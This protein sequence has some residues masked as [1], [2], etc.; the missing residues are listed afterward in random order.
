MNR[1]IVITTIHEKTE[2]ISRFQEFKDW[3]I[4]IIGDKKSRE[5]PSEGNIDFFSIERQ[6]GLGF[7]VESAL[8]VNHYSRKN[9]GYL[10]SL[11]RNSEIVYDTDDDNLP[12]DY[13]KCPE[14]FSNTILSTHE[15]FL[16]VYQYFSQESIWPRGFPLDLVKNKYSFNPTEKTSDVAV[17]QGLADKD[18]DVDAIFR[19]LHEDEIIFEEK[20][21]LVLDRGTY[22]PFNS[23]NTFW[24]SDFLELAYLPSTVTFRFTD[25]L[26]GY[27][28]QRIMWEKNHFLGFTKATVFQ[29]RNE[30]DLMKDF[31]SEIPCYLD[32]HKL[33]DT[34]DSTELSGDVGKDLFLVYESLCRI[35]IVESEELCILEAWLNDV[36]R[37][38]SEKS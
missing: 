12:Y 14:F 32:V 38:R 23:Q 8:P 36:R 30:H 18:P 34:L 3:N 7:G 1:S 6:K 17:W 16:N 33:A 20:P 27:V 2:A 4:L 31:E 10:L 35:G 13:W 22:C 28:A 15:Q 24:K 9:I 21:P 5:I 25:I 19:L 29:E 37:I 26:R 11:E